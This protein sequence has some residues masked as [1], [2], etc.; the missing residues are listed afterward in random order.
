M[1]ETGRKIIGKWRHLR[2]HLRAA[3]VNIKRRSRGSLKFSRIESGRRC[4]TRSVLC[5]RARV[6]SATEIA[7][8][9]FARRDRVGVP[10]E[11]NAPV[12]PFERRDVVSREENPGVRENRA[13]LLKA[14]YFKF[15]VYSEGRKKERE[16]EEG[17]ARTRQC[18]EGYSS[19]GSGT[20]LRTMPRSDAGKIPYV[21]RAYLELPRAEC[22]VVERS[23]F[24]LPSDFVNL[25]NPLIVRLSLLFKRINFNRCRAVS[26]S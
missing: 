18:T 8:E 17:R 11:S 13:S 23:S 15:V 16:E 20:G 9:R 1:R 14:V 12:P 4:G 22:R 19:G 24:P 6:V 21:T 3:R 26:P 5:V 7:R 25:S 10:R 2:G